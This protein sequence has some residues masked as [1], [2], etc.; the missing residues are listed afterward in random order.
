[1]RK[2]S[3]WTTARYH[4]A[5]LGRLVVL[6]WQDVR[7]SVSDWREEK[8]VIPDPKPSIVAECERWLAAQA[9][10]APLAE[11]EAKRFVMLGTIGVIRLHERRAAAAMN[12]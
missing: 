1:M 9:V 3:S 5:A 8:A 2:H 4:L 7:L 6:W 12:N 11:A 10:P